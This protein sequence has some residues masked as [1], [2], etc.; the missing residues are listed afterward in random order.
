M[1]VIFIPFAGGSQY[2]F[3]GFAAPAKRYGI[4]IHVVEYPG[5]GARFNQPFIKNDIDTLVE[6]VFNQLAEK[7]VPP[8][9]IFGHSMGALI[10]YLLTQKIARRQLPLPS[11]LFCS[12]CSAPSVNNDEPAKHLLGKEQFIAKLREYGGC[13]DE[14]LASDELLDFFEPILR[15]DFEVINSY[16]YR[17]AD[18]LEVPITVMIG[19]LDKVSQEDAEKWQEETKHTIQL[20]EFEG[21]HFFIFGNE[22]KLMSLVRDRLILWGY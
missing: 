4:G 22:E 3:S 18:P 21:N 11:H 1:T 19:S 8:Y 15:A 7:L 9:V 2:S 17:G 10:G 16:K 13:P 20:I 5:R 12:G 14:V 6:D